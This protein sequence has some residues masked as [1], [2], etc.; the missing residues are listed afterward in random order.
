MIDFRYALTVLFRAYALR[1][2]LV[3]AVVALVCWLV[4]R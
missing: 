3:L 1:A 4:C 2:A